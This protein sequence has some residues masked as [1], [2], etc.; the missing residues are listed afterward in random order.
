LT[1]DVKLPATR[2]EEDV[3][4][5][6]AT[7]Q[8]DA[9]MKAVANVRVGVVQ[10]EA[11]TPRQAGDAPADITLVI[12]NTDSMGGEILAVADALETFFGTLDPNTSPTVELITFKDQD[13]VFSRVV[14]KDIADVIGRVRS[15]R[16]AGGGDCPNASVT[17]LEKALAGINTKGQII[18]ATAASAEKDAN[19]VVSKLQAQGVK[20]NVLLAGSCDNEAA[21]KAFY[22]GITDN[23]GGTFK[24]LPRGGDATATETLAKVTTEV[25][26]KAIEEAVQIKT[27]TGTEGTNTGSG[28]TGTTTTTGTTDTTSTTGTTATTGTTGTTATTG[29]T[30]TT[31]TTGTTGTTSTTGT[32]ATTTTGS[33]KASG[34]ISDKF[35]KPVANATVK[36]GDQTVTTNAQGRWEMPNLPE[37]KYPVTVSVPGY[38]SLSKTCEV[39]ADQPC[40]LDLSKQLSSL[41]KLKVTP[42]PAGTVKQGDN[43]TYTVTVTNTGQEPA[44]GVVLNEV[45]PA[46]TTLVSMATLNGSGQCDNHQLTCTLPDLAAGASAQV[47][48][49]VKNTQTNQLENTITVSSNNYPADV[50]K[51]WTAVQPYLSVTVKDTPDPVAMQGQLHYNYTVDLSKYATEN[52]TGITLVTQLPSGVE[53][54]SAKS[55]LGTCDTS[56]LPTVTC[57]LPDLKAGSN[58]AANIDVLLK[59]P[60]LLV[61]TNEAKVT[62]TNY[63]AHIVRE[64]TN[65]FIPDN[66]KVDLAFVIDTTGSMQQ[67][68]NGVIAAIK[69][70]VAEMDTTQSPTMALI[71]FKDDVTVKAFTQD[72]KVLL[73]VAEELKASG[74]GLCPEASAEALEVAVKHL[75]DGGVIMFSTDASPYDDANLAGLANLIGSKNMKFHAFVTGDCTQKDSWNEMTK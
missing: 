13:E 59:D 74:G 72:P 21:D 42:Q 7:S 29:T 37:G 15:I 8:G 19:A 67:E 61:L 6:T 18:L 73:K 65:I 16:P 36:V 10:Q 11:I 52:A 35:G 49:V 4:T 75:K 24:W 14:T 23:T 68:I 1:F 27:T 71:E 12:D 64:R 22:Q 57:P 32:T 20:V 26:T 30:G 56:K 33:D 48:L 58:T 69:K 55:D 63:P 53:I 31:T 28:T 40:S 9:T 51:T 34:I 38:V 46:A 44:T 66:I 60:G 25:V 5:V 62:A 50:I 17:A 2:G 39:S 41:L 43:V 45:L 47:K 3:I 54:Q 70:F